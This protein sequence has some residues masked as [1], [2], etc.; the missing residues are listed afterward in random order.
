M[1]GG[2]EAHERRGPLCV[3]SLNRRA[4]DCCPSQGTDE[5]SASRTCPTYGVD[6]SWTWPESDLAD[7]L[8]LPQL[9]SP[10]CIADNTGAS[11]V[12]PTKDCESR[13]GSKTGSLLMCCCTF[14]AEAGPPCPWPRRKLC[15]KGAGLTTKKKLRCSPTPKPQKRGNFFFFRSLL[16]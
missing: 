9:L 8:S 2:W 6:N 4:L 15:S 10:D 16:F 1:Q 14:T 7:H 13:Q 5:H 11:T 3:S 12:T